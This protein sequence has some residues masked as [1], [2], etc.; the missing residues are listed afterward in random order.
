MDRL[1]P[2]EVTLIN[3]KEGVRTETKARGMFHTWG[4]QYEEFDNHA[5]ECSIAIIELETG[6]ITTVFPEKIKFIPEFQFCLT[7]QA[8]STCRALKAKIG[9]RACQ[10][11][12]I[13]YSLEESNHDNS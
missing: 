8:H 3:Y 11:A 4:K 10:D 9:T 1:R 7:C 5:V 13:R 12:I 6:E 2:V